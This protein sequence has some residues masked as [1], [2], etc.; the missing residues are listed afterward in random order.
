MTHSPDTDLN[1]LVAAA[2]KTDREL[3]AA[4]AA[5]RY[6]PIEWRQC[7]QDPEAGY[8]YDVQQWGDEGELQPCYNWLDTDGPKKKGWRPEGIAET[9]RTNYWT[10]A[11]FVSSSPAAWGVLLEELKEQGYTVHMQTHRGMTNVKII[12]LKA[13]YSGDADDT[14][15]GRAIAYA[16]LRVKRVLPEEA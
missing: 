6:G 13:A 8:W 14:E 4:V 16:F 10:V 15:T 7:D 5:V 3:D 9:D 11:P 1:R 2:P 12:D